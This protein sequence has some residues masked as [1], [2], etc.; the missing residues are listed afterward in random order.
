MLLIIT[1]ETPNHANKLRELFQSLDAREIPYFVSRRCDPAIIKRTDIRGLILPGAR[2]R[3]KP[4]VLQDQLD[5]ELYYLFH[6]PSLPVLGICH[7]C[8]FLMLYYGGSLRSYDTLYR[9]VHDVNLSANR[10]F[11]GDGDGDSDSDSD[12]QAQFYFHDLPV[13]SPLSP[14]SI[15]EIAWITKFRDGRRHACAFEFVKNRVYGV[16]FHP[17][18]M[19]ETQGILYNFYEITTSS[20]H[21]PSPPPTTES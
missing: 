2:F 8:Q 3:V 17:E 7:G 9:G 19:D 1:R 5:L 6:F 20:R 13:S 18:L 4:F 10:L 16:M 12:S 14:P 15:R 11:D 21:R